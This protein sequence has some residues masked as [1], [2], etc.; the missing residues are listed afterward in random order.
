[1]PCCCWICGFVMLAALVWVLADP[2]CCS[3]MYWCVLAWRFEPRQFVVS[4]PSQIRVGVKWFWNCFFC[5]FCPYGSTNFF[6]F[7]L[8]MCR[9]IYRVRLEARVCWE[10][11][12]NQWLGG[13][14]EAKLLLDWDESVP[15]PMCLQMRRVKEL[16]WIEVKQN[17]YRHV[18]AGSRWKFWIWI[19]TK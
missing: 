16:G 8:C 9:F 3:V 15:V 17:A 6:F 11:A 4:E 5:R 7:L 2:N 10:C 14:E 13:G 12:E 18:W 19:W 1:M